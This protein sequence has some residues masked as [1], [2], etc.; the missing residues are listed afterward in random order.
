MRRSYDWSAGAYCARS[1][2]YDSDSLGDWFR[3]W[4]T[5]KARGRTT[6]I[7]SL[8]FPRVTDSPAQIAPYLHS[9]V[10]VYG[11][12]IR[13]IDIPAWHVSVTAPLGD[14]DSAPIYAN[15]LYLH[16]DEIRN[17]EIWYQAAENTVHMRVGEHTT[18]QTLQTGTH[19]RYQLPDV[20]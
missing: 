7:G 10:E 3:L 8:R 15:T 18:R 11:R 5:D 20:E 14:W 16:D 19:N 1:A 13:P 4:L 6:W 2:R 12:P 9:T 17:T